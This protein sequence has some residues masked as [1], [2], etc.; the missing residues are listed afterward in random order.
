MDGKERQWLQATITEGEGHAYRDKCTM[1]ESH[2]GFWPNELC[3]EDR[4]L[5]VSLV[6]YARVPFRVSIT[7][8][9]AALAE[10]L[11]ARGLYRAVTVVHFDA[12]T[13]PEGMEATDRDWCSFPSAVA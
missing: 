2:L 8:T 7:A 1:H 4:P 9:V 5:A 12:E 6:E 13:H 11:S 10:A 3:S